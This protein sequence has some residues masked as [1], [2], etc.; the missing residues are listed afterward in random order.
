M[1]AFQPPVAT[2]P[3]AS[4]FGSI[5]TSIPPTQIGWSFPFF[6]SLALSLLPPSLGPPLPSPPLQELLPVPQPT[7]CPI[8][9]APQDAP[10]R[11][12]W[13]PT[14]LSPTAGLRSQGIIRSGSFGPTDLFL[15]CRPHISPLPHQSPS[16]PAPSFFTSLDPRPSPGVSG[17]A[18]HIP[19]PLSK[20][21]PCP[22]LLFPSS[23]WDDPPSAQG[24]LGSTP[25]LKLGRDSSECSCVPKPRIWT[26]LVPGSTVLPSDCCPESA[27]KTSSG[28]WEGLRRAGTTGPSWA[29]Q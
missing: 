1:P 19:V 26:S 4:T 6:K 5:M 18:P 24:P 10:L 9:V 21:F 27:L 29:V 28:L 12:P 22:P 2:D 8:P 3:T 14:L 17:S 23:G 16:G 20:G 13:A 11:P 7:H 15:L 25:L